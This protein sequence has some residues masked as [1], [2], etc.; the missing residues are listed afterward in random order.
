MQMLAESASEVLRGADLELTSGRRLLDVCLMHLG[1]NARVF[2]YFKM[3]AGLQLLQGLVQV[4]IFLFLGKLMGFGRSS[5]LVGGSYASYLIIGMVLLQCLDKSLIA[6]YVSI[7]GA[8]WSAR[9]ESLLLSPYSLWLF[10]VT[11]TVWYYLMTTINASAIFV[12]GIFFGASFGAPSSSALAF[13]VFVGSA[14]GV[15]GLGLISAS[16]FSLLNAK[17]NDEPVGWGVHLLQG[18]VTGL[19]FPAALL[20]HGLQYLGLLLPHTYAIDSARRLFLHNYTLG[21][22]LIVHTWVSIDPL[23]VN[24]ACILFTIALYLPLGI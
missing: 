15:F 6:P 22:S 8:Y 18:L 4:V 14:V 5:Q 3:H 21:P 12:V 16:T 13:L 7:S 20:P 10:I 19:Y 24:L 1:R 9:L 17:G 11:D 23:F 2:V